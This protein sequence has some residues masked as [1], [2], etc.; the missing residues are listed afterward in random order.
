MKKEMNEELTVGEV[1]SMLSILNPDMKIVI[2]GA[3]YNQPRFVDRIGVVILK[4]NDLD[5]GVPAG[6]YIG[7]GIGDDFD[8]LYDEEEEAELEP[9]P[10]IDDLPAYKKEPSIEADSFE[11]F[12][13]KAIDRYAVNKFI[14]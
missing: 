8:A 12:Q 13:R 7:L 11:E 4:K 6:E 9:E 14:Q 2:P 1:I 5:T 10:A 3:P